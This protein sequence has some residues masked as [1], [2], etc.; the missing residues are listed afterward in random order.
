MV[1]WRD[2]AS[3]VLKQLNV[4][5][6]SEGLETEMP[7]YV[8]ETLHQRVQ[9]ALEVSE[10]DESDVH[11]LA[12]GSLKASADAGSTSDDDPIVDKLMMLLALLPAGASPDE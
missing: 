5:L 11:S 2:S 3:D 10:L 7:L 6:D 8:R 1:S 4:L 12:L 9:Q